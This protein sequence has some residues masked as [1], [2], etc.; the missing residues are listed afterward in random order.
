MV[1]SRQRVAGF[2]AHAPATLVAADAAGWS[3]ATA[4]MRSRYCSWLTGA[5]SRA[6]IGLLVLVVGMAASC[7]GDAK[8]AAPGGATPFV[9]EATAPSPGVLELLNQVASIRGLPAPAGLKTAVV[10]RG[11]VPALLEAA[12]TD[13]DRAWFAHTTTLYRLLGFFK[14]DED[15][16]EVYREFAGTQVVGLYD[17]SRKTLFVVASGDRGF[18]ELDLAERE[19]LAHELAHALQD[20]SFDLAKIAAGA[21]Q[22]LDR[23][24]VFGALVE[25]DAVVT[26]RLWARRGAVPV[27]IGGVMLFAAPGPLPAGTP[28]GIERELRF[29]YETGATWVQGVR[30]AGGTAAVDALFRNLP[31]GTSVVLHPELAARGWQP[32]AVQLPDLAPGLGSGWA[33]ESGGTLGEFTLRNWL[34]L[35]LGGLEAANAATGWSGDHYDVYRSGSESVAVLRFAFAAA[36]ERDEFARAYAKR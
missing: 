27:A 22:D 35:Q 25:G 12:L 7:G 1:D 28:A 31:G 3:T 33:R 11:Q 29:P 15:Y 14:T 13:A 36:G 32:E 2:Q 19:T 23:G 10:S 17:P 24:L 21:Q 18:D 34:Q 16:L 30:V 6:A 5:A 9:F 8:P 26:Q 4:P 20:D